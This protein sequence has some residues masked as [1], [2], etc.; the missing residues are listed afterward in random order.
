VGEVEGDTGDEW[1]YA[2]WSL[3]L[4]YS[5][6]ETMGHQIYLYDD[7]IYSTMDQN[8]DFDDDGEPGGVIGGFLV[9]E[10]IEGEDDDNDAVKLTCFVGEGDD[11]YNY[12]YLRFNDTA[13]SDGESTNDVWNSWSVGLTEDGIDID[14]FHVTWGSGLLEPGDTSA[15]VDLPTA[16]DSWNLVYIILSFRSETTA[17]GTISYLI[18]G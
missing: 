10:Q 13:L 18:R 1:S 8:V 9:P 7:F 3:I 6:P 12:D 4:I 2:A 15:E 16:T 11:Y 17:G 5:S 14:T